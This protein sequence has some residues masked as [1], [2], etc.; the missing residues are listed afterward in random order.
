VL[1][2]LAGFN[3]G[4]VNSNSRRQIANAT[5][6]IVH[7]TGQSEPDRDRQADCGQNHFC[8]IEM[9]INA[10]GFIIRISHIL[11]SVIPH[12]PL[13]GSAMATSA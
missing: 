9:P 3:S 8:P 1:V 4:L 2:I 6:K 11:L 12:Q 10:A 13:P 7:Q 5:L